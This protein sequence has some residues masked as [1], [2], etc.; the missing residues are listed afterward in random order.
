VSLATAEEHA[1][2]V[3]MFQAQGLGGDVWM[4]LRQGNGQANPTAGW[5]YLDGTPYQGPMAWHAGQPDDYDGAES[6]QEQC[7]DMEMGWTWDWNDDGCNDQ[8]AYVCEQPR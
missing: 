4:G 2:V 8:Q 7:G 1:C 6:G 3:A 5:S